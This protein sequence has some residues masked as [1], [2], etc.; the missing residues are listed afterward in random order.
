MTY[1]EGK[2]DKAKTRKSRLVLGWAKKLKAIRLLGGKCKCCGETRPWILEFHHIDESTKDCQISSLKGLSWDR[3]KI[4][5]P[6]C[7]L[8]CRNCHG[9]IHFKDGFLEFEKDIIEKAK[10]IKDNFTSR[11]DHAKVLQLHKQRLS[12][13][14]IAKEVGC[15]ISTV[16][17]ILKSNG[18]HTVV[19]KLVIDPLEVIR[20]R[21]SGLTN[22]EIGKKLG[23]HRL[24]A[25][26]ILKRW[27]EKTKK[28]S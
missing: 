19:K 13:A 22:A 6:K 8:L 9:D 11:V 24:T 23:I 2:R 3:F 28:L 27:R 17:E 10:V 18:I 15:G 20:L 12:Q 25:P 14:K 5:L 21:E 1:Y 26:K 4:E 7:E 16:C